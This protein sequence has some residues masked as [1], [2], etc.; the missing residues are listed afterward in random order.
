MKML[1]LSVLVLLLNLG[2]NA[3]IDSK[4]KEALQRGYEV[5]EDKVIF[6]DG[7]SCWLDEFN[8]S[9]CGQEWMTDDY[10]IAAGT[11]VWDEE[12]CCEGLVAYLPEETDGQATCVT[13]AEAQKKKKVISWI[14]WGALLVIT[15]ATVFYYRQKKQH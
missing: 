3:A 12:R 11:Y 10:C 5:S 7:S 15:M 1:L 4:Y 13:L 9:I 6:P 2:T 8:D 14:T